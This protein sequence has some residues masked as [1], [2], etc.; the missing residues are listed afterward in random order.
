MGRYIASK[1]HVGVCYQESTA[2]SWNG[3]PD[4]IYY[5]RFKDGGKLRWERC[6]RASDGWT[7]ESAQRKRYELLEQARTGQY[8][9]KKEMK[10]AAGT[11]KKT[12]P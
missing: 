11:D 9:S 10:A 6:G 2:K 8:K 3:R 1:K 12:C 7:S 5:V 4:R